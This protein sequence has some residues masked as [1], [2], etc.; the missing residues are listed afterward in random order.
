M[1]MTPEEFDRAVVGDPD[2]LSR[3][4]LVHG[5]LIVSP[6][7]SEA[8]RDP[9]DELGYLL[10]AYKE[11]RPGQP[12]LDKTLTEQYIHFGDNRRRADRVIWTGLGRVPDPTRDIPSIVVEFVSGRPRDRARDHDEKRREYLGLGVRE[13][14]VIDRF[15]RTLT[16]FRQP[17]ALPAEEV[18]TAAGTYRTPLLPGFE[19]PLARLLAAADDWKPRK[20]KK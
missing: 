4:E 2:D 11:A 15:A 8:E 19:L 16:I 10:R 1:L 5:V 14:W 12:T 6:I 7:P 18:V 20:K 13:Y 3:Y 17:P 9:N